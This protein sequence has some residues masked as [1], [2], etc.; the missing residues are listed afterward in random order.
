MWD[1]AAVEPIGAD[2]LVCEVLEAHPGTATVFVR[3]GVQCVGC[4][5]APFHTI[6]DSAREH[7]VSLEFLLA[8]LNRS[9]ATTH[10]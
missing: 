7:A 6:A 1:R 2:S 3:H 9:V 8:D 10:K 5:I 4:Y